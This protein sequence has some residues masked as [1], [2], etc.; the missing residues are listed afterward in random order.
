MG[1]KMLAEL[2]SGS[3]AFT[4]NISE[5]D[6]SDKTNLCIT[7][8]DDAAEIFLGD[9]DFLKRFQTLMSNM[10]QYRQL[11]EQYNDIASVD[12]RFDGQIIY[13]PRRNAAPQ[14]A[15]AQGVRP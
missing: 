4:R 12:L 2:E 5:V 13:R 7:L 3:L 11:K 15:E 6:I 8:V 9:R 10:S 1:L 14:T